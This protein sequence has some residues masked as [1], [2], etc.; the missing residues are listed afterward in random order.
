MPSSGFD[1]GSDFFEKNYE[2]VYRYVRGIVHD[3]NEAEDLTRVSRDSERLGGARLY[4]RLRLQAHAS[5]HAGG[6]HRKGAAAPTSEGVA[7]EHY[8]LSAGGLRAWPQGRH[9]GGRRFLGIPL[10]GDQE[11]R[12]RVFLGLAERQSED[13]RPVSRQGRRPRPSFFRRLRRR[14]G[15]VASA[16]R[17]A[18]PC[19]SH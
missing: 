16:H 11:R 19:L 14:E 3:A 15:S 18:I 2:L 10:P 17:R 5:R 12:A 7:D 9:G 1:S 8:V 4:L 13:P 6:H